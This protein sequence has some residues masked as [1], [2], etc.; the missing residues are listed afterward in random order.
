VFLDHV[1]CYQDLSSYK[2]WF[3]NDYIVLVSVVPVHS[4]VLLLPLYDILV[5]KDLLLKT[6]SLLEGLFGN[7]FAKFDVCLIHCLQPLYFQVVVVKR[8]LAIDGLFNRRTY[9]LLWAPDLRQERTLS[10]VGIRRQVEQFQ[11]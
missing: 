9:L 4:A 1:H 6:L 7:N 8:L 10:R 2:D 5:V 11:R 3:L